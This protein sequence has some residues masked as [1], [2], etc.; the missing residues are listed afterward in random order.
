[1]EMNLPFHLDDL[2][3]LPVNPSYYSSDEEMDVGTQSVSATRDN[4]EDSD[5]EVIACYRQVPIEPEGLVTGRKMPVDIPE[6]AGENYPDFPWEDFESMMQLVDSQAHPLNMGAGPSTTTQSSSPPI[7]YCG[8]LTPLVDTPLSPPPH[9]RGPIYSNCDYTM[10]MQTR[11]PLQPNSHIQGL[12]VRIASQGGLPNQAPYGDCIV[13][14]KSYE[15]IKETAVLGYLESTT[16]RGES[17]NEQQ[18]RRDASLA[19][20]DQGIVLLVLFISRGV[21]PVAACDG[22]FYQ[23]TLEGDNSNPPPGVLPI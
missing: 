13:C 20:M 4:F 3:A 2:S 19:G 16:H 23:I 18:R 6:S 7:K 17:Y 11:T 22:N 21:S 9:E 10:P 1:M 14:G 12:S 5:I 15:Q 8:K